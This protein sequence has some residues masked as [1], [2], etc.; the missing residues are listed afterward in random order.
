[1]E[2]LK[3]R[4]AL[5]FA[6]LR[7]AL[8][9]TPSM[10]QAQSTLLAMV[11][12]Y[13]LRLSFRIDRLITRWKAGT[14]PRPGAPRPGRGRTSAPRAMREFPLPS[15]PKWLIRRM[16]GTGIGAFGGQLRHLLENDAELQ[17][18]L[19]AS[20]QARRLLGP[21]CRMFG[22]APPPPPARPL[23][24]TPGLPGAAPPPAAEPPKAPH[25]A[26]HAPPVQARSAAPQSPAAPEIFSST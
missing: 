1:M 24:P 22:I 19:E 18:L 14:L 8:A 26:P 21:L 10:P 7:A 11:W 4:L 23:P 6:G 5:Y 17:A 16:P 25:P 3:D 20:P 12:R 15:R 9:T 2:T 13:V